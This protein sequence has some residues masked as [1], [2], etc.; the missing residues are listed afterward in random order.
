MENQTHLASQTR[1]TPKKVEASPNY[2]TKTQSQ[3]S[4]S[5]NT[6]PDKDRS[7]EKPKFH[8]QLGADA[9]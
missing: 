9:G 4:K 2:R 1:H 7:Q 8:V 6:M 3:K 5:A